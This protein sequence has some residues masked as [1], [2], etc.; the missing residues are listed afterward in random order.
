[1]AGLVMQ[2]RLN[3]RIRTTRFR[4]IIEA[5]P[6]LLLLSFLVSLAWPANAQKAQGTYMQQ[7]LQADPSL[8]WATPSGIFFG[9]PL[10]ATQLN[11]TASVTGS[12]SYSPR[13]GTVLE[14]GFHHLSV[15]FNPENRNFRNATAGVLLYVGSTVESTFHLQPIYDATHLEVLVSPVGDFH[16]PIS[17]SCQA[18][19][20]M[21]CAV[22]PAVVRLIGTPVRVAVS[23]SGSRFHKLGMERQQASFTAFA[24]LG[25]LICIRLMGRPGKWLGRVNLLLLMLALSSTLG[26][27]GCG[28]ERLGVEI[29]VVARSVLPQQSV[30]LFWVSPQ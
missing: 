18:P 25:W 3:L 2:I 17:F 23:V 28:T 11:A 24:C 30:H 20:G 10:G 8:H 13:A 19:R 12:F 6:S 26:L 21:S 14:P 9:V 4:E 16:S 7:V 15:T 27:T 22:K 1:M 29:V 5:K